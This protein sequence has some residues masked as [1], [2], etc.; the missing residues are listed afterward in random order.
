MKKVAIQGIKREGQGTKDAKQLRRVEKVP[1][2][3]YGGGD[4]VHFAADER[5]LKKLVFTPETYRIEID[6]DG[7][8]TMALLQEVQFHPVTDA[9][10]HVDFLR[11]E[12]GKP[13]KVALALKFVGQ[14]EG[15]RKGGRLN[16][17][18]RK[19]RVKGVPADLPEHLEADI[20]KLDLGQSLRIR[21]L[22]FQG[23][24]ILEPASEV[25]ATVKMAK[26]GAV[27]E[28]PA[29]EEA[30]A[31]AEGAAEAAEAKAE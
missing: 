17:T 19:L 12:P 18:K 21:D 13:A 1:C 11:M 27:S 14:S 24:T 30:A 6:I 10:I 28:A 15:V 3:L 8:T 23:L 22:G 31:P 20:T 2:V 16:Q 25:V 9:I 7:E 29:D 4:T 5:A 26:G